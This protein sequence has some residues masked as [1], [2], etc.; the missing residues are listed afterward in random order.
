[1]NKSPI[2]YH[3]RYNI[4]LLGIQKLHPF[5]SEKYGRVHDFLIKNTKLS[6]N[7]FHKPRPVDDKTLLTVHSKKYIKSLNSSITIAAVTEMTLLATIPNKLL[8]S[9][10]LKPMKYAT[11]GTIL[12]V[13]LAL[14]HGWAINLSGGYHHAKAGEGGGFCYFADIPIAIKKLWEKKPKAKVMVVDLDAHQGN[15]VES[16]LMGE[17]RVFIM[18]VYNSDLY[19]WDTEAK[20]GISLDLPVRSGIKD[21]DYLK[22]VKDGL[23]QALKDFTPD[24]VIFNAGTDV[25][26]EDDLGGMLVTEKGIMKRDE[27]VFRMGKENDIPVLMVLSGGYNRKSANIIGRSIK[28]L[29]ENVVG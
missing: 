1:M 9:R 24:L 18:D 29:I 8:Q 10:L 11:G 21:K 16:V 28:N 12:G 13:D 15:G 4:T 22:V 14:K 27:L 17:D 25:F 26:K 6:K 2:I 7:D 3:P 20:K 19:P 23:E 5:D